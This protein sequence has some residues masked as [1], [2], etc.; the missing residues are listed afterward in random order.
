VFNSEQKD[1][2]VEFFGDSSGKSKKPMK[3]RLRLGKIAV[4]L[5]Y[6]NILILAISVVM[7]LI[8]CYSLGVEKGKQMAFLKNGP[9]ETIEIKQE[10]AQKKAGQPTP[11]PKKEKPRVK[12][13]KTTQ[14]TKT[15]PYIQVASFRTEKYATEE[16]DSLKDK[17]YQA[18]T[19]TWGNYKVVC[20]GGYKDVSEASEDLGELK[21]SYADCILHNK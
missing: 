4:S 14:L 20:V 5:S 10:Q 16:Q 17:G 3:D 19:T 8:V 6:E 7:L 15:F 1:R 13:A 11:Q 18:F 21:E 9:I 2:Q 12:V